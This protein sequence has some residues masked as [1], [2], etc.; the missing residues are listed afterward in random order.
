MNIDKCLILLTFGGNK[1]KKTIFWKV[2]AIAVVIS[3]AFVVTFFIGFWNYLKAY[4]ESQPKYKMES[5]LKIFKDKNIDE[6]M[7][8]VTYELSSFENEDTMKNYIHNILSEGDWEFT[9]SAETYTKNTPVYNI[10]KNGINVAT[11]TLTKATD[12]GAFHTDQWLLSSVDNLLTNNKEPFVILAP[13]NSKVY[14][15]G[16][17]LTNEYIVEKDIA[18]DDL[19]NTAKYVSL[20]TMVKYSV[21]GFYA[22]PEITAVGGI[23]NAPLESKTESQ[24]VKFGFESNQEFVAFQ[25]SRV[26]EITQIYGKYV[27][28]DVKFASISPYVMSDSYAY[29]FLK[30]VGAANVWTA[31]HTAPEF[32][33]LTI[34]NYQ[35]YTEN[36]FSC[37]VSFTLSIYALNKTY[38]YP[39]NLKYYFIKSN[40]GW[41]IA[42]FVIK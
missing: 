15:N 28:N 5:V 10:R 16:I 38:E 37:E 18:I 17:L 20:P 36:C 29:K 2:Y 31:S 42:D 32:K 8:Y 30:T 11:V 25:E 39:T 26:K 4:E 9:Q 21:S 27:I 13:S 33:N 12:K 19:K 41:Y 34:S 35:I 22:N 24:Q 3:V 23:F 14:V 1:V 40:N 6:I 7:K